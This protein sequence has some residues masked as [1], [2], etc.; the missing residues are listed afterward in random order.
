MAGARPLIT[1][2]SIKI[3]RKHRRLRE[4]LRPHSPDFQRERTD[5]HQQ[6]PQPDGDAVDDGPEFLPPAPGSGLWVRFRPPPLQE[7]LG[8]DPAALAGDLLPYQ[9]VPAG[10]GG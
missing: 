4:K 9:A 5:E 7:I 10:L 8:A 2:T 3:P 6:H 1:P